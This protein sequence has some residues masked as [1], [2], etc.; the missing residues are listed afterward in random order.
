MTTNGGPLHHSRPCYSLLGIGTVLILTGR[1]VSH[2]KDEQH[3]GADQRDQAHQQPPPAV[4]SVV[5]PPNCHRDAGN[6]DSQND[7]SDPY[8]AIAQRI[9]PEFE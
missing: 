9:H 5:E 1:T 4:T 8:R 2:H 3:D 7:S 6:Q